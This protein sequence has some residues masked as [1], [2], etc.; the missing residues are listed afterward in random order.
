ML[1]PLMKKMP[2]LLGLSLVG[3][4]SP[5]SLFAQLVREST[6]PAQQTTPQDKNAASQSPPGKKRISQEVQITGEEL[7]LDSGIDIQAGE[8]VLITATGKLRYADAKDDNGPDGLPRS[9]ERR[10]GKECRSRW[11][12]YH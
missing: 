6:A 9:E 7:W 8:H 2:L 11:S 1:R 3:A 10:V 12:P 4:V 5:S